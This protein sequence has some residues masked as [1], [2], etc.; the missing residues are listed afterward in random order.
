MATPV[1]NQWTHL[2]LVRS[3]TTVNLYQNGVL[4]GT[5]TGAG[6][7][8]TEN[9]VKI[10]TGSAAYWPNFNGNLN[11]VRIS[12]SAIYTAN[13][14]PST[15]LLPVLSSTIFLT[16]Q[17]TIIR[18]KST[19]ALAL[20]LGG[21]PISTKF[22]PFANV[23]TSST[24]YS[25]SVNGGS[26]YFNGT[27]DYL[28][29]PTSPSVSLAG[30]SWTIET[31]VYPTSFSTY[32]PIIAKRTGA[33]AA[34]YDCY[35]MMGTGSI[36]FYNGIVYS[37]G[38]S[39]QLNAWSHIAY[40]YNGTTLTIYLNGVSILSTAV[41]ITDNASSVYIGNN[42]NAGSNLAGSI[43]DL[44]VI[45]GTALYTTTFAPPTAPLT[46]ITNTQLLLSGTNSSVIDST[47]NGDVITSG[48][49]SVSTS[50]FKYGKSIHIAA[51]SDY[52]AVS[53]SVASFGTS[54]FTIEC[55]V[56]L[57]S[58][59]SLYPAI[60]SNYNAFGVQALG[61]FAGHNTGD[62]ARYQV[63]LNGV[64]PSLTST[65]VITYGVW[66]HIAVVRNSGTLRLYINGVLEGSVAASMS[67]NGVG[68]LLYIGNTGDAIA[69][70]NING[71]IED[72]RITKGI[73]RY[74]GSFTPPTT[75]LLTS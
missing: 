52:C 45:K 26:M 55:W 64:F 8:V 73:A 50:T 46:A 27:T 17:D 70:A 41:T 29:I 5:L 38:V 36:N 37:S 20:T 11:S 31:Y 53:N 10:G 4:A 23:V 43:S 60:F 1:I 56:N 7:A 49:T 22:N 35:L 13:F 67:I 47:S 75:A 12:N 19:N 33:A 39:P 62:I 18:D 2:A 25:A 68:S 61:L 74:T 30:G 71:Y 65:S 6:G 48:T 66:N 51:S 58:R 34:S 54:D 9:Y 69:N 44:R 32:R 15:E 57:T 59:T 42:N 3:G 21:T 63:A 14:T 28:T 40:V 24:G 16:G 72:F